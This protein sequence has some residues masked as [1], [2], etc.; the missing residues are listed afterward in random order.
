MHYGSYE[1]SERKKLILRTIID[2]Y[3]AGGEPVGSKYLTSNNLI[4]LSSATIRNEMAELE[5]L[6]YLVQPHTSAGRIPS[7]KGYRFYVDILMQSYRLTNV[8][9][10]ELNNLVRNKVAELDS[11]LERAGRLV[12]SLTNY[13]SLTV[14]PKSYSVII[15]RYKILKLS[16][17]S[18]LIIMITATETVKTKYIHSTRETDD[19]GL[20]RLENAL[21]DLMCGVELN[22]VTM[23][24]MIQLQSRLI[25]YESLVAPVMKCIYEAANESD[26]GDLRLEGVNRLLQYPEFN[27]IELLS[28]MLGMLERKDDIL[29]VVSKS[30]K[31]IINI[32]IGNENSVDVMRH[33]TLIFKT[34]TSGKH[35]VGAIG[36]IGPCR[37]DYSKVVTTVEYLTHNITE[38]IKDD[39]ENKKK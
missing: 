23:P 37:M 13:T 18:F 26:G 14:K 8:E 10:R 2:A 5:E 34:I 1:L 16:S 7:E 3:I 4:T 29:D 28:G 36:V 6:G 25:G 20:E 21:N 22:S 38:M 30:D 39:D 27:N 31:N 35:I 32:Y 12:S 19:A 33:T 11:I 15:L 24:V 9:I 17:D